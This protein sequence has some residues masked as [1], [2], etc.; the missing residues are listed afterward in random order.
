[1]GKLPRT[2]FRLKWEQCLDDMQDAG[3]QDYAADGLY[4]RSM[5]KLPADLRTTVLKHVFPLDEGETRAS[6]EL[7]KK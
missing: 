2:A 3:I 7:G 5:R 1:M 4:R 6:P